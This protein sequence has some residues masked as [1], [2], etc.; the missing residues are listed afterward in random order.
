[1]AD[2]GEDVPAQNQ[3]QQQHQQQI[4]DLAGPQQQPVHLNWYSFKPEF[5]R[6]PDEDAET[7]LLHSNDWMNAH[8]FVE[9]VKSTDFVSHYWEKQDY[10]TT[11]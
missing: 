3:Q 2:R 5:S 8:S 1:M 6:K 9:G 4:Q 11:H 7:H 10:G